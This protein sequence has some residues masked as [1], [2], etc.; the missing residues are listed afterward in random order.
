MGPSHSF[1]SLEELAEVE[2]RVGSILGLVRP[3][4]TRGSLEVELPTGSGST[5]T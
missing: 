2:H 3:E 1:H 4:G 5:E